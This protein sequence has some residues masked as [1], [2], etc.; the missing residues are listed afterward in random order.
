[1]SVINTNVSALVAQ[2]AMTANSRA[3]ST[4]MSQL[5]TGTRIN[6]AK[7]D[8]AGLSIVSK[9]TSQIK[10]LDQSVRN[11]GDAISMLQT[12]E[13]AMVEVTNMLQR[14]RELAVQSSSDTYTTQDRSYLD[15]EFQQLKVE[16][17]RIAKSTQWN[18]NNIMDA[19]S[20]KV[21]QVG[22][23]A[24]TGSNYQAITVDFK[25][26]SFTP[27]NT[28][29]AA[30]STSLS[31][32]AQTAAVGATRFQGTIGGVAVD[33]T[34]LNAQILDST[35]DESALVTTMASQL[36][37]GINKY[38]GLE[39][40]NV[41]A[42][43]ETLT[44]TDSAGRAIVDNFKFVLDDGTTSGIANN[45]GTTVSASSG[46]GSSASTSVFGSGATGGSAEIHS[47]SVTDSTT[48]TAA[49]TN[50]D[51][52][53]MGVTSE[54]SKYGAVINRL[55]YAIDNLSNQSL[56]ASAS[57]SRILDTDYAKASTELAR[58]QIISQAATAMLAQANQSQQS[59]LALLK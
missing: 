20:S 37:T 52:A 53:I 25:D 43:G 16:I 2:N 50:L 4:A 39:N 57:R 17:N 6:S 38:A 48:A 21:F 35:T 31:L 27:A 47:L 22:A 40:I 29:V 13:G 32:A 54:R 5:S 59:V 11:A 58:T 1:M 42:I 26:F 7:D 55:T 8:A 56:N 36:K 33:V 24:N 46:A 14:M 9:M 30:T 3:Q 10:G 18:G 34:T 41:A 28:T 23:N 49:I 45:L 12:G 44:F 51:R 15:Q 19:A